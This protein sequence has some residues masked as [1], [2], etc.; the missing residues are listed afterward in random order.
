[1]TIATLDKLNQFI[2]AKYGVKK[3]LTISFEDAVK[4]YWE[5]LNG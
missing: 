4:E 5:E 1:M 2:I 3:A